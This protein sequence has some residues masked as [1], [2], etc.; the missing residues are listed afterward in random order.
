M[1]Q[2]EIDASDCLTEYIRQESHQ[3]DAYKE[4]HKSS[5]VFVAKLGQQRSSLIDE[6]SKIRKY[7][8]LKQVPAIEVPQ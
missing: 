3:N 4:W 1:K 2:E 7:P 5:G 8:M 6:T